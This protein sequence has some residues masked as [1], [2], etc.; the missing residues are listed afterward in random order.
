MEFIWPEMLWLLPIPFLLMFYYLILN[1]VNTSGSK[2]YSG[3][4]AERQYLLFK[5][6]FA[7]H[8]PATLFFISLLLLFFSIAR[9]SALINLPSRFNTIILAVDISASMSATDVAPNRFTATKKAVEDFIAK[10]R[11]TTRIGLVSFADAALVVQKP[12]PIHT[13]VLEA[14]GKL[15][16]QRGTAI[17]SAILVSLATI[18]PEMEIDLG[19]ADLEPRSTT[20]SPHGGM[21]N[22]K[23]R[24]QPP[25]ERVAAGSYKTAAIILLSDGEAN[26]GPDPID[27]SKVAAERGVRVY[28]VGVGTKEGQTLALQGWSMRTKLDEDTMKLIARNTGAEYFNAANAEDLSKVY[29]TLSTQLALEKKATEITAIVVVLAGIFALIGSGLSMLWFNRIL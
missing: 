23:L 11:P 29:K 14:L 28:T 16:L 8:I 24:V 6:S 20:P 2:K 9:P 3:I 12:T 13:D 1:I 22:E 10:Q 4:F 5:H 18:F 25:K 26:A 27:V 19:T 21:T 17:G 7:R 15:E